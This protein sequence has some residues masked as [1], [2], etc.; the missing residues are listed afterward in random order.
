MGSQQVRGRITITLAPDYRFCSLDSPSSRAQVC[1]TMHLW[2]A[3]YDGTRTVRSCDAHFQNGK[4][5]VN[6]TT[7]TIYR[8][9]TEA[10]KA[11]ED[12]TF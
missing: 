7:E 10:R 12:T 3:L 1:E 2:L 4:L 8:V 5:L 6:I 11:N 9:E